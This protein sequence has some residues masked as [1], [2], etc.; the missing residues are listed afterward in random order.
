[1]TFLLLLLKNLHGLYYNMQSNQSNFDLNNTHNLQ[2][3]ANTYLIEKKFVS[4]HSQD[5]NSIMYPQSSNFQ[6][7]L[8]QTLRNVASVRVSTFDYPSNYDL[9]SKNR[10]NTTLAFT[11][12]NA[13]FVFPFTSLYHQAVY[14]SLNNM[15]ELGEVLYCDIS[16]GFY[17]PTNMVTELTNILNQTVS[18][19]VKLYVQ[20]NSTEY[21]SILDDD[22]NYDRFVVMYNEVTQTISFGNTADGFILNNDKIFDFSQKSIA[23]EC[24]TSPLPDFSDWGLPSN[25]GL[26]RFSVTSKTAPFRKI[27]YGDVSLG[28][29]GYWLLPST[30]ENIVHYVDCPFKINLMGSAN[31]YL[32]IKQLNCID[33]TVPFSV[34]GSTGKAADN[35]GIVNMALSK[36]Q[37][38]TTPITQWFGQESSGSP[39]KYFSPPLESIDKLS[40]KLL[41]HDGTL[42][43]FENFP[44]SFML[45]FTLL[46]PHILRS[47]VVFD[48]A[49]GVVNNIHIK[50]Q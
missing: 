29:N 33:T 15:A 26:P 8:P 10:K 11:M 44:Y 6:I 46:V 21:E 31:F 41:Y 13:S 5:R 2:P 32:S 37:I 42:V 3:N 45:E 35:A 24:I 27:N 39:H 38:P 48:P 40:I 47:G 14:N 43:N 18:N 19:Q 23:V 49:K 22:I 9:F 34:S 50:G 20:D 16:H 30:E 7:N 17:T 1:M 4:I 25:I 12:T 36:I 28:D